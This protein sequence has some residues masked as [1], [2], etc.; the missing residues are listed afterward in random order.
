MY[1]S[2]STRQFFKRPD[3]FGVMFNTAASTGKQQEAL[4]AACKYIIDNGI[5]SNKWIEQ[6]WLIALLDFLPFRENCVGVIVPDFLYHEADNKVRGDWKKTLDRFY[7]YQPVIER[8]GFPVALATQDGLKPEHVPWDM[9]SVL[10][11]GGSNYH[12][13]GKEAEILALE[14]KRRNKW[15]HVGRVSSVSAMRKLWPWANSYDGT[16]FIFGPDKKEEK[17]I[18]QLEDF[19]SKDRNGMLYQLKM[20]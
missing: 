6:E 18:P 3:L 2:G 15:V 8:F 10:F 14:A 12:K 5:Y 17:Y 7:L 19:F 16:T 1:F 20:F 13:R 4:E 11:I 9:F